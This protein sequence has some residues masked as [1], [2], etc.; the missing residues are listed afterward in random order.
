MI[1]LGVV[2]PLCMF[3]EL[4]KFNHDIDVYF[5]STVQEEVGTRGAITSTYGVNPDIGIAID[6][7]FGYTLN[8]INLIHWKSEKDQLLQ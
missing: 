4:Q 3:K 7:G 8:S 1:M 5:V 6:V 2:A